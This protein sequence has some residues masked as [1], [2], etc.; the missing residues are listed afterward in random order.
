MKL[1]SLFH[2]SLKLLI[3]L[4]LAGNTLL[5]ILIIISGSTNDY[6]INRFYWVEGD[7]TGIPNAP[8]L[9]RWTFWGACSYDNNKIDCGEYLKPAAPIS[10]VDNFH[11]KE[12]VPHSFISKRDAFYYLSRFAFCFFWIAL[13][14]VG[15][16]FILFILSWC[17]KAVTQVIFILITFGCVFNITAVVLIQAAAAMAKKAFSDADRHGKVGPSLFGIAWASVV[18]VLFE[19]VTIFYWFIKSK[20]EGKSIF[21]ESTFG[22]PSAKT[23]NLFSYRNTSQEVPAPVDGTEIYANEQ[24]QTPPVVTQQ[25]QQMSAAQPVATE[26]N[27]HGINFFKI[28]R[29]EKISSGDEESV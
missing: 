10:P 24:F 3:L 1:P 23:Q 9:T 20:K 29:T 25:A 2:I 19:F 12:N 26:A 15:I 4:F 14:F 27:H 8:S 28:K 22:F 6:P 18:L 21:K 17:S 5:L 11:T 16:S 13:A 7:T